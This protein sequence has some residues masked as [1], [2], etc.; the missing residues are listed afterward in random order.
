MNRTALFSIL[1]VLAGLWA[2]GD[3]LAQAAEPAGAAE[4]WRLCCRLSNYG[5]YQE[6]A[7]THIESLGIRYVFLAIPQPDQVDATMKRLADHRLEALVMRG[8]FNLTTPTGPDASEPQLAAC[9]KMGCHYMFISPKHPGTSKEDACQ[10]LRRAGDL[11]RRY[12][13]TIVLETHPDLGANGEVH[14][15]TMKRIDHPNVRVNFDTGNIHFYNEGAKAPAELAK[16]IDYVATVEIKDH[17]GKPQAWNFP[18][19]GQGVVD[20]P[21]VVRLLREHRFQGPVTMEIEGIAGKPWNEAETLRAV[22]ESTE[23]LRSLT[24]FR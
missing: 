17:F 22:A 5:K 24:S 23:Y 9:K 13:V 16:I 21:A 11:A 18:A 20:I 2:T 14:L 3:G 1:A 12:D 7:W 6:K 8:E 10:R 19:L 4:P 15:E